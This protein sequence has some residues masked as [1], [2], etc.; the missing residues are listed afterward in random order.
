M[1]L[2]D[3]QNGG[4]VSAEK[5][6]Q[7]LEVVRELQRNEIV[8][9]GGGLEAKALGR[10]RALGMS[11]HEEIQLITDWEVD[12]VNKVIRITKRRVV[13]SAAQEETTEEIQLQDCAVT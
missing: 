4:F 2:P 10:G 9:V 13:I 3:R 6:N 8:T 7:L 5:F 12:A 11:Q 1:K